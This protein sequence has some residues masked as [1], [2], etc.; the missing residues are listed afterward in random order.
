[1]DEESSRRLIDGDERDAAQQE[2]RRLLDQV[3]GLLA[4]RS[5]VDGLRLTGD[6]LRSTAS[7][8]DRLGYEDNSARAG[9]L[10]TPLID[11]FAERDAGVGQIL[12]TQSSLL[13]ALAIALETAPSVDGPDEEISR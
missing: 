8:W 12:L 11:F 5:C 3:L 7:V 6:L 9:A 10:L 13:E 4:E 1:M 2:R